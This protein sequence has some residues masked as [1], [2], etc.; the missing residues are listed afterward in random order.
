MKGR[1]KFTLIEL[2]V[3]IAIIAILAAMLLPA[4]NKARDRARS[5]SCLS[6]HKQTLLALTQYTDNHDGL[7]PVFYFF[8]TYYPGYD[9]TWG[10][11]L[12]INKYI[13]DIDSVR[14]PSTSVQT[15]SSKWNFTLGFVT[16]SDKKDSDGVLFRNKSIKISAVA[17]H[18]GV[19]G[20]ATPSQFAILADA[21]HFNSSSVNYG[22]QIYTLEP[23]YKDYLHLRH[24]GK[25]NLGFID[26][27]A[28]SLDGDEVDPLAD[29][30]NDGT[31]YDRSYLKNPNKMVYTAR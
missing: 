12:Y 31:Q 5:I 30:C 29:V 23:N 1:M 3:V 17:A 15:G 18:Q 24:L 27:S 16:G 22:R 19:N 6:N 14:C 2:L 26:G 21:G 11:V 8:A 28:R 25:A 13:T 9:K 4:L 7:L 20:K 10:E